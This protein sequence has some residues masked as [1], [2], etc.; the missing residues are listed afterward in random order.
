MWPGRGRPARWC[1]ETRVWHRPTSRCG[2]VAPWPRRRCRSSSRSRT[3]RCCRPA[4]AAC[5]RW[6]RLRVL[7]GGEGAQVRERGRWFGSSQGEIIRGK[8]RQPFATVVKFGF[9]IAKTIHADDSVLNEEM[10]IKESHPFAGVCS[11]RKNK[12]NNDK[13][14]Y[15]QS[16]FPESVKQT[17]MTIFMLVYLCRV[18]FFV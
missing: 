2:S 3:P 8:I 6:S 7:F 13:K 4:A 10:G 11:G 16:N 14:T 12:I 9:P 5:A 1:T 15:S 17:S 18:E